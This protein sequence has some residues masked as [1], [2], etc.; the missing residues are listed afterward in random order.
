MLLN[1][2]SEHSIHTCCPHLVLLFL[3]L[4]S[5]SLCEY[6]YNIL[7]WAE[8]LLT[9]QDADLGRKLIASALQE[10]SVADLRSCSFGEAVAAS[11]GKDMKGGLHADDI[12]CSF[13]EYYTALADLLSRQPALGQVCD[14]LCC[15]AA[16]N[17]TEPR[18]Q[19][20]LALHGS[21]SAFCSPMTI[22]VLHLHSLAGHCKSSGVGVSML[23]KCRL[24]MRH[25]HTLAVM[26][27]RNHLLQLP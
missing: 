4:S 3:C 23:L 18:S 1:D 19:E 10:R 21:L 17:V 20:P 7:L 27:K 15:C 13:A 6:V 22:A 8:S 9:L 11:Q 25:Y 12:C 2:C 5:V 24:Q 14:C 16:W 26:W